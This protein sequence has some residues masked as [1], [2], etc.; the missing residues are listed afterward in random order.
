[1]ANIT[2]R[3][4]RRKLLLAKIEAT[5]GVDPTPTGALN[6]IEARNVQFTPLES[7]YVENNMEVPYFGNSPEIPVSE[8]SKISFEVA[9]S[10]AAAAGSAPEYGPLLRAAGWAEKLLA[11][12][13][14]GTAQS[15]D[16]VNNTITLAVGASSVDNAYKG[17]QLRITSG[18]SA[19]T[20]QS[21][22]S[23]N[24]TTKV[25]Q[26]S[27]AFTGTP[28]ATPGYSI[29][30]GAGY[31]PIS[32]LM[33]SLTMYVYI[34]GVLHKMHSV[35]GSQS[36]RLSPKGIALMSFEFIGTFNVAADT[37]LITGD[38]S[39]VEAPLAVM[40][41]NVS[42]IV[43]G[44]Y[45]A[46]LYDLSINVGQK[47]IHRDDVIGIDDV[48]MTDRMPSGNCVIQAP[49][50][51]DLAGDNYFTMARE[52]QKAQLRFA[53]IGTPVPWFVFDAPAT[54]VKAP[55]YGEKDGITTLAMDLRPCPVSGDDEM[56]MTFAA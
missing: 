13:V 50:D 39:R 27:G 41:S 24:G 14:T 40:N 48:V 42:K 12:A 10:P 33:E 16:T 43:V 25:A 29:E 31:Y 23:Y 11:V 9:I 51:A 7:Q 3:Y 53:T 34:D 22:V 36:F 47:V 38:L 54:Q 1:M 4:W 5:T 21:I 18:G 28:G 26:L 30:A 2:Q 55:K 49:I 44:G 17:L 56:I 52:A 19:G 35:R 15:T 45:A 8:L 20:V 46:N 37:P 6:A 32:S